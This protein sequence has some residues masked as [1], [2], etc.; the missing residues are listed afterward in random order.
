MKKLIVSIFIS[1]FLTFSLQAQPD[2]KQFYSIQ[3]CSKPIADQQHGIDLYNHLKEK[4]YL[5]YYYKAYMKDRSQWVR[6]RLGLFSTMSEA[7]QF[8]ENL[9]VKENLDYYVVNSELRVSDLNPSVQIVTSPNAIWLLN[10]NVLKEI[11]T[12]NEKLPDI[13]EYKGSVP[14]ISPD[15]KAI[16]FYYDGQVIKLALDNCKTEILETE[17]WYSNPQWSPS[18]K[19][20]AFMDSRDFEVQTSLIIVDQ[21]NGQKTFLVDNHDPFK[22]DQAVNYFRWHP[23]KDLLFFVEGYAYGTVLVGGSLYGID[24]KGNRK[25]IISSSDYGGDE[26]YSFFTVDKKWIYF[27]VAHRDK[28]DFTRIEKETKHNKLIADI[29]IFFSR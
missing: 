5:A 1:L 6:V 24:L 10:E 19:Y 16:V 3:V 18:G 15:G 20:I 27:K 17:A 12:F 28:K 7:K 4:G 13:Y 22:T 29:D 11:F 14:D 26:I 2:D 8:G 23:N 21:N 9:K 25:K